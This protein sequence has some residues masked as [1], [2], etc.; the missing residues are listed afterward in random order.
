MTNSQNALNVS[1]ASF[2]DLEKA[3]QKNK[4]LIVFD[5]LFKVIFIGDSAVGKSCLVKRATDD[6]FFDEHQITIGVEFGTILVRIKS[7]VISYDQDGFPIDDDIILKLQLWDTAGQENYQ[8]MSRI[9]YRGAHA[10]MLTYSVGNRSSLDNIEAHWLTDVRQ[11]CTED[12]M[13]FLVGNQNDLPHDARV[14]EEGQGE[15]VAEKLGFDLFTETSAK[16]GQNVQKLI[17][18]VA[19]RLYKMNIRKI[20]GAK[21]ERAQQQRNI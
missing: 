19:K 11:Q 10:A 20:L 12:T 2:S 9:F 1:S 4:T 8:S 18:E 16:S 7:P 5:Y 21:R 17:N 13:F 3:N 6:E 15:A 14:V